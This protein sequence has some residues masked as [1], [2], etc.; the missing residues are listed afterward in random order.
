MWKK[1]SQ[2]F[3]IV[4]LTAQTKIQLATLG[5]P[6]PLPTRNLLSTTSFEKEWQGVTWQELVQYIW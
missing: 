6:Q 3:L 5:A 2:T 4:A 1:Q